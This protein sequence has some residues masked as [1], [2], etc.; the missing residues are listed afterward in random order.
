MNITIRATGCT[1]TEELRAF[2]EDKLSSIA[3][4]I[5]TE[6][7][8]LAVEIAESADGHKVGMP[9]RVEVTL[10]AAGKVY[11]ASTS[12]ATM[13]N[14]IEGTRDELAAE[15]KRARGKAESHLKRGGRAFKAM[16][17]GWY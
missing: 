14:A 3:K 9:Y 11:R 6:G 2:I 12:A 5:S 1:L 16:L 4:L 13:E 7:A 8:L 10:E 15:L 17:R